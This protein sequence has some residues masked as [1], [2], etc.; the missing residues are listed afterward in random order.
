MFMLQTDHFFDHK[1]ECG[2]RGKSILIMFPLTFPV[3]VELI[4]ETEGEFTIIH[5]LQRLFVNLT[6]YLHYKKNE[7]Q[8]FF[9]I[10]T[11]ILQHLI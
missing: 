7:F 5:N 11:W 6:V 1:F 2:F 4:G 3:L 9:C 10:I 8:N